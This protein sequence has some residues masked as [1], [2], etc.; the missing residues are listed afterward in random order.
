MLC[1]G[2][3]SDAF[4]LHHSTDHTWAIDREPGPGQSG[5]KWRVLLWHLTAYGK[6]FLDETTESLVQEIDMILCGPWF[7]KSI[8][9]HAVL[10][11]RN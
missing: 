3:V 7:K 10:N 1:L 4:D 11:L 8:W 9:Y 5:Y 6:W 2:Q